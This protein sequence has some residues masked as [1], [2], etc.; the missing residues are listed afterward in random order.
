[1]T[2]YRGLEEFLARHGVKAYVVLKALLDVSSESGNKSRIRLGDFD[3]KSVKKKLAEYGV[4]YNPA[5]LLRSLER[6]YGIIETSYKSSNQHWWI[7]VD[8]DSVER[9]VAEFE[10]AEP[11]PEDPEIELLKIQ[12]ASIEPESLI[13]RLENL[14]HKQNL[15]ITD[16]ELFRSMVFNEL[17]LVTRL[18]KKASQYP[19]ALSRD[20]EVLSKIIKLA[21]QV[22][23]RLRSPG[24]KSIVSRL[25]KNTSVVDVEKH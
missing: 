16:K 12:I 8:R 3:F 9:V 7:F 11:E 14:L 24:S 4:D 17:E 13:R 6:E 15:S 22:A 23:D 19:E 10:G 21:H 18:L 1:M 5:L 25:M 20:V 2:G